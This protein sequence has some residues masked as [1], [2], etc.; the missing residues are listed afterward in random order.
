[1]EDKEFGQNGIEDSDVNLSAKNSQAVLAIISPSFIEEMKK[2]YI[3][4]MKNG[5][6]S[7]RFV[8][9]VI[10]KSAMPWTLRLLRPIDLTDPD[11]ENKGWEKLFQRLIR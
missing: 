1:M 7:R 4:I 10:Q 8:P 11:K 2:K 9:L 5:R 6:K 3:S